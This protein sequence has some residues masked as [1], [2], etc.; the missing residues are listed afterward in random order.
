M[1][2]DVIQ[3]IADPTRRKILTIVLDNSLSISELA[4]NQ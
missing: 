4:E 3:A 2:R 1:K